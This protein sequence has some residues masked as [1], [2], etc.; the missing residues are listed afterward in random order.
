[1][2]V[3]GATSISTLQGSKSDAEAL[4]GSRGASGHVDE[5]RGLLHLLYLTELTQIEEVNC[6]VS[7]TIVRGC[8]R[9]FRNR[10]QCTASYVTVDADR[11]FVRPDLIRR[12]VTVSCRSVS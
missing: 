9:S 2:N 6:V 7:N 3:F 5:K 12:H 10:H 11:R 4:R 1:M 8:F